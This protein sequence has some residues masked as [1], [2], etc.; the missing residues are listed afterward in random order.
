MYMMGR[1]A[2]NDADSPRVWYDFDEGIA[3][4]ASGSEWTNDTRVWLTDSTKR[5]SIGTK[6]ADPVAGY[7]MYLKTSSSGGLYVDADANYGAALFG[8]GGGLYT[9]VSG[10]GVYATSTGSYAGYFVRNESAPSLPVV[11]VHQDHA[12]NSH[13]GLKVRQDG[14][15][16]IASF[17]DGTDTRVAYVSTAGKVE[18]KTSVATDSLSVGVGGKY[19]RKMFQSTGGDSLGVIYYNTV[20][21]RADTVWMT[22]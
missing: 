3:T 7:K 6:L 14:T 16:Q 18:G 1:N 22:Q 5:V 10:V 15:G 19:I 21:V 9:N 8:T 12:S 17:Y 2:A 13:D 20:R 4:S 11:F